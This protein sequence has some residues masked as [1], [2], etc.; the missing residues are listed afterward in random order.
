VL[1]RSVRYGEGVFVGYRGFDATRTEVAYPF[2]YGLSYTEFAYDDV[3]VTQQGTVDAEDLRLS[4]SWTLTNTGDRAGAE[5]AQVYVTPAAGPV[6]RPVRELKAFRKVFLPA[7][8]AERIGVELG[9]RDLAY[10]SASLHRWVVEPGEY[11][12][13]VGASSRDLRLTATIAVDAPR[14]RPPLTRMSPLQDWRD[15]PDAGPALLQAVGLTGVGRRATILGDEAL[16]KVVGNFP[17]ETLI[18]FPGV[19]ITADIVDQLVAGL[20]GVDGSAQG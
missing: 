14:L 17:L 13:E 2:G 9:L 3:E 6:A 7:T 20:G 1:F 15:D 12:I 16:L 4:V 11:R 8:G 5:V 10:W 19:G 18:A